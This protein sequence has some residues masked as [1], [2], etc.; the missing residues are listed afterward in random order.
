MG[1][2]PTG[3][4]HEAQLLFAQLVKDVPRT[5][6]FEPPQCVDARKTGNN[7]DCRH[8]LAFHWPD[9]KHYPAG[10]DEPRRGV[11]GV[12]NADWGM[13]VHPKTQATYWATERKIRPESVIP[14]ADRENIA[15]CAALGLSFWAV[16]NT[17]RMLWAV[18]NDQRAHTVEIDRK[19]RAAW[20]RCSTT[21]RYDPVRQWP[22][23]GSRKPCPSYIADTRSWSPIEGL[24][25][26]TIDFEEDP[27]PT[28]ITVQT[29]K[30]LVREA[31]KQATPT[32]RKAVAA[33]VAAQP[34]G[35]SRPQALALL[36][37]D[38][39]YLGDITDDALIDLLDEPAV[40]KYHP[41][42]RAALRARG[43]K[44]S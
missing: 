22:R 13:K 31:L 43:K 35:M 21:T 24:G 16:S 8:T 12:P 26:M 4:I 34:P 7:D 36:A 40:K 30:P 3:Q 11:C 44:A 32:E 41:R 25:D 39:D 10:G 6:R 15:A 5:T 20:H 17:P 29:L 14:T 27:V 23:D 42:I 2:L 19:R 38:P 37:H 33:A 28:P 18:D 9:R 1:A